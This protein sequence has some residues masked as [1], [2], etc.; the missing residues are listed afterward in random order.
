MTGV[1]AGDPEAVTDWATQA[2]GWKVLE[3]RRDGARLERD[4]DD[5]AALAEGLRQMVALGI[6]VIEFHREQRR[7]EEAFVEM[8]KGQG[9]GA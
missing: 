7:L 1:G 6:P 8:V 5:P 4:G 9:R 2:R 3:R